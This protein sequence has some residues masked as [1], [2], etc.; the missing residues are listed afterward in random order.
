LEESKIEL[1]TFNGHDAGLNNTDLP[2]NTLGLS[3]V[4]LK[5]PLSLTLSNGP[6][7]F[8]KRASRYY[9]LQSKRTISTNVSFAIYSIAQIQ[10]K[11]FIFISYIIQRF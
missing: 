2:I 6:V 9:K 10:V 8:L 1:T 5:V 7:L 4:F 11:L 3:L